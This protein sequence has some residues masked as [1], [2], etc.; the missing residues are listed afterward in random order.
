MYLR[1]NIII[2]AL[3][4]EHALKVQLLNDLSTNNSEDGYFIVKKYL[5]NDYMR[6]KSLHNKIGKSLKSSLLANLLTCTSYITLSILQRTLI[7]VVI[8]GQLNSYEMLLH[9]I[10]VY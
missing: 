2:M 9:T 7:S 8:F 1:K 6:L 5:S 4:I 3:D 10:I